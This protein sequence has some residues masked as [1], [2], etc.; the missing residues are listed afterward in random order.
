MVKLPSTDSP[1]KALEPQTTIVY[2]E[3]QT[4]LESFQEHG[5]AMFR[6]RF[7]RASGV[8]EMLALIRQ[9][10]VDA[11]LVDLDT[12]DGQPS[13]ARLAQL[14]GLRPFTLPL[15]ALSLRWDVRLRLMAIKAGCDA[16]FAKPVDLPELAECLGRLT[17][18]VT[19]EPFR[20]MVVE[21]SR[22]Q[23]AFL[24]KTLE[25][26]GMVVEVVTEPLKVLDLLPMFQPDLILMD[27]YMPEC[28]GPELASLIRM[29][30]TYLDVPIVFLSSE[31]DPVKQ[32]R[33]LGRGADDFLT[34]DIAG[35]HLLSSVRI[36]CDRTR[37]LRSLVRQDSLTGLLNHNSLKDRLEE[38]VIRAARLGS[39][40]AF[41]MIDLDLFKKVR[42]L[43][44]FFMKLSTRGAIAFAGPRNGFQHISKSLLAN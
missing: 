21:D 23:A 30:R 12:H 3:G 28:D 9:E 34:K 22:T 40:L 33:A 29:S 37:L 43:T 38:E 7:L 2:L 14:Q 1:V 13:E 4:S 35:E 11:L 16:L 31:T 44:G 27:M 10:T 18:P 32:L 17:H 39:P 36:R 25:A 42:L 20:V 6:F 24:R 5:L 15:V 26:G 19:P 8:E 41:A